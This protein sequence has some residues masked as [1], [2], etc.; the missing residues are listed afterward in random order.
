VGAQQF[1]AERIVR[2]FRV[3]GIQSK[4]LVFL[5]ADDLEAGRGVPRYVAQ[6]MELRQLVLDS[7]DAARAK[8][9]LL[10]RRD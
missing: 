1:A 9:K 7:G 6:K 10:T 8:P 2:H 5:R 3:A 4:L